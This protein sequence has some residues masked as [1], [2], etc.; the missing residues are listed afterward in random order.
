MGEFGEFWKSL[1]P[2][3]KRRLL[4]K[5]KDYEGLV[6]RYR[7]EGKQVANFRKKEA[8]DKLRQRR[9]KRR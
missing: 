9:R 5:A 4:K 6:E 2:K 8:I 1:S 3:E 7:E